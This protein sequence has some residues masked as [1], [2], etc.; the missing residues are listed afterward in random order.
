MQLPLLISAIYFPARNLALPLVTARYRSLSLAIIPYLFQFLPLAAS[1]G[2]R[3]L[4][5]VLLRRRR[6]RS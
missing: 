5:L 6:G 1:F 4:M 2:I 3:L